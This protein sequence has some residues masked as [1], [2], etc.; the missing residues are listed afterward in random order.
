MV[1]RLLLIENG[2]P[3]GEASLQ[4]FLTRERGFDCEEE[5]WDSVVAGKLQDSGAD[6]LV[7]VASAEFKRP[8]SL[9]EWLRSHLVPIP[10]LAV[11][12]EDS[13]A[14]VIRLASQTADDFLLSPVRDE[15]LQCRLAR[16]LGAS[17][18]KEPAIRKGLQ[19]HFGLAQ[20]VGES[21]PFV[22]A[23]QKIPAIAASNAPVV[24][25]G[26]TGTGKELCAQAIHNLGPRHS[27]AFVPVECGAVPEHLV[28][29]ELFGHVR[30]A[31]TDAHSDQKG[32]AAMAD[33]G[34]LFLDEIDSLP[35]GAQAKLLRF[36]QEG[37]YRALGSQKLIRADVR[38]I[39]ATNQD[40]KEC[41]RSGRF[42]SDLYFRLNVL[43]LQ[44]PPLRERRE[45]IPALANHFLALVEAS[46]G[47]SRKR[48]SPAALRM[49]RNYDWPGNVRELLNVVQRAFA[50]CSESS[51]LPDHLGLGSSRTEVDTDGGNFRQARSRVI[52]N[53]EKRYLEE[54]LRRHRG[55]VTHAALEAGKDRRVF[56]RLMKKYK[57]DPHSL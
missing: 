54:M 27:G 3:A 11:L 19:Q 56:G 55:N 14:E 2:G 49:L 4:R 34:T 38:L 40:L 35:L 23:I 17:S 31:F 28:E 7:A 6:L 18:D 45:D 57:V 46:T 47:R 51:I 16:I 10:I 5:T 43:A 42:R 52:E 1:H 15:E 24:L 36:I 8:L 29:N 50:F 12:P 26:E 25:L 39:A 44:L 9:F 53:F 33:R 41:V 37:T 21:Q 20:F 48:F 30:G 32:L 22:R 13:S